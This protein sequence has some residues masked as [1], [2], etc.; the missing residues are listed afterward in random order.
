LGEVSEKANEIKDAV[1]EAGELLLSS[2]DDLVSQLSPSST[3]DSAKLSAQ[4]AEVSQECQT[5]KNQQVDHESRVSSLKAE[6]SKLREENEE[7][8]HKVKTLKLRGDRYFPYIK[9]ESR[10]FSIDIPEHE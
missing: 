2:L 9:F 10:E 7:Y 8:E 1:K 6:I 4:L 3:S 5:L